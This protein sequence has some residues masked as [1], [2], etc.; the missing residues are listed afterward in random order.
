MGPTKHVHLPLFPSLPAG[1]WPPSCT[2]PGC[3]TVY[4]LL[5]LPTCVCVH[6]RGVLDNLCVPGVNEHGCRV[7]SVCVCV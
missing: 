5:G 2:C 4:P 1:L 3:C 6:T 7:A